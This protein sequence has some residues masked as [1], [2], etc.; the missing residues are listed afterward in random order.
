M[1]SSNDKLESQVAGG[2]LERRCFDVFLW[3]QFLSLT[4]HFLTKFLGERWLEFAKYPAV[5]SIVFLVIATVL[6]GRKNS[7][8]ILFF[9]NSAGRT[10]VTL[11]SFATSLLVIYG[12]YNGFSI[13]IV[14]KEFGP[15][16]IIVCC[17]ILGSLPGFFRSFR[18]S[19]FILTMVA[20]VVN[21]LGFSDM[22]ELLDKQGVGSRSGTESVSYTTY[23]A[24]GFW[25]LLLLTN[26]GE[27]LVKGML[28]YGGSAFALLQQV[29]FQKRLGTVYAALVWFMFFVKG[30]TVANRGFSKFRAKSKIIAFLLLLTAAFVVF[31]IF[32]EFVSSQITSLMERFKNS[33]TDHRLNE[34]FVMLNQLDTTEI[35]IGKGF[36]GYYTIQYGNK[37][38]GEYYED[39][40]FIARRELHIGLAMPMLKGGLLFTILVLAFPIKTIF[41]NWRK[42]LDSVTNALKAILAMIL[43][44]SLY[45]GM[46]MLS[47]PYFAVLFGLALG[48]CNSSVNWSKSVKV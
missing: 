28:V 23:S 46:F 16:V 13:L 24:L 48:R 2:F 15:Y 6:Y 43:C 17:S 14:M 39:L 8:D 34:S 25:P 41:A 42:S 36:G 3:G 37:S 12:W 38:L 18:D 20:V 26:H 19:V 27:P 31:A 30:Q 29:F 1:S 9:L 35:F 11:M 45:G 40:G 47:E 21:I 10:W 4:R 33:E 44:H 22:E 32:P 5:L 7:S